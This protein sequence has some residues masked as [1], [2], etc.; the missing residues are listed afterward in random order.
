MADTTTTNLLLTKP[1]V[2]ASTDTWGTKVNTDLDSIDAVFAAAGTGTSVGLNVGVG[3]TLAVAGAL[4]AT[5][6]TTLTTPIIDNPKLGYA[7]T[8]TAAGTTTLTVTSANQQFFTGTTTQTVVLPVTSTL[9]LGMSYLIKNNSTGAVT[10]QSSGANTVL[11]V[12]AGKYI[13]F[14]CILITGT[15]AASWDYREIPSSVQIQPITASVATNALTVTLNPTTLDFRSSTL[16][17]GTVNTRTVGTAI[18]VT[19]S[20]GSTLGT[21]SASQSRI[22]VIAIDNSGTVELAVVN[23]SGSVTLDESTLIST[24]AEG[25]AG[26]ADSAST[27]YSTTARTSVPFRVVGFVESTQTTAGTWATA[28]STIQGAGNK[29]VIKSDITSG[30]A[31]TLTTQTSVIF[32]S[33][34]SWVKRVTFNFDGVSSSGSSQLFVRIGAASLESTGYKGVTFSLG[35]GVGSSVTQ[36]G[37]EILLG[38]ASS[39]TTANVHNG[40][41]VFNLLGSNTWTFFGAWGRSDT[42]RLIQSMGSKII[43]GGALAQIQLSTVNGTDTFDAGSI[44]ILYE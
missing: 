9:A 1:E 22:A 4:T 18:S 19:V 20:S 35:Q 25:G 24:T 26:A 12:A 30:T 8:A 37:T 33:I 41:I 29:A 2:G 44:N 6:V 21:V 34:P 23:I 11:V 40:Y 17:S 16:S 27:I 42:T 39:Q 5:G 43:S 28:P 36:L 38:D 31:V 3:K 10:V 32:S 7:T 14:T 15:T 13:T